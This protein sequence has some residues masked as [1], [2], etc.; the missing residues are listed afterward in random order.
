MTHDDNVWHFSDNTR[1]QTP[2]H[3][4][5]QEDHQGTSEMQNIGSR[6]V[7][8]PARFDKERLF[9]WTAPWNSC[10]MSVPFFWIDFFTLTTRNLQ[11][12]RSCVQRGL[13]RGLLRFALNVRRT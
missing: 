12:S 7:K 8:L 1:R 6:Q 2:L 11:L 5:G 3:R 13:S 4:Y 10:V 9:P